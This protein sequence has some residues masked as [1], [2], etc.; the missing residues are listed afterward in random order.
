MNNFLSLNNDH[1]DYP[2]QAGPRH[3]WVTRNVERQAIS[4][5]KAFFKMVL[6]RKK[7]KRL[8]QS[9]ADRERQKQVFEQKGHQLKLLLSQVRS[10]SSKSGLLQKTE[11]K[12]MS[13]KVTY[14]YFDVIKKQMVSHVD[15]HKISIRELDTQLSESVKAGYSGNERAKLFEM[16]KKNRLALVRMIL[17]QNPENEN[18]VN[19]QDRYKNSVLYYA[20]SMGHPLD[21]VRILVEYGADPN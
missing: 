15:R 20:V 19:L 5:I 11:N 18:L 9:N 2:E 13:R 7:Y 10:H 4:R 1:Y 6:T 3:P 8:V 14:E 12:V 17:E 16:T 21:L